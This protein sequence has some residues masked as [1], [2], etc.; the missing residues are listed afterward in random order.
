MKVCKEQ[1]SKICKNGYIL[2]KTR[3]IKIIID[4]LGW[5]NLTCEIRL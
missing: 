3:I 2:R 4:K 5:R 1:V